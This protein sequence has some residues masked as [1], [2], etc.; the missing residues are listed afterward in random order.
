MMVS[1]KVVSAYIPAHEPMVGGD[2]TISHDGP[3]YE[4]QRVQAIADRGNGVRLWTRACIEDV[5]NLAWDTTSIAELLSS[6]QRSGRFLGSEWCDNG[7]GAWA[8]CDAYAITRS[9]WIPYANKDMSITYYLKFAE[10]KTGQII[11][12]ASCHVSN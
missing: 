1:L 6:L 3:L 12:V 8:A 9:E 10:A 7:R 4:L 5:A 11:L 2:R